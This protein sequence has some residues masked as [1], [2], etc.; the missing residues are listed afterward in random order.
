MKLYSQKDDE[1]VKIP[2]NFY[3]SV[4]KQLAKDQIAEFYIN[5]NKYLKKP[6][7]LQD[8]IDTIGGFISLISSDTFLTDL[9]KN[10][11][12]EGNIDWDSL[13]EKY[14]SSDTEDDIKVMF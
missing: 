3:R 14:K 13:L 10:S 2:R 7:L 12:K 6:R 5:F 4:S 11:D 9:N 8:V 1:W